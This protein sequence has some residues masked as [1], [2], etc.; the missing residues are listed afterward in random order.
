MQ[1]AKRLRRLV[2][3][4]RFLMLAIICFTIFWCFNLLS[5]AV[6]RIFTDAIYDSRF[7]E[8]EA[9]VT[10]LMR[11]VF[12]G[13]WLG[14][15]ALGLLASFY[16]VRMLNQIRVGQYFSLRTA[17]NMKQFGAALS[18]TMIMDT[19]LAAYA[20][21]VLTWGN[22]PFNPGVQGSIGYVA[23]SYYY[24]PGDIT[25]FFCGVGFFIVGWLLE[26]GGRIEEEFKAIV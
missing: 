18:I 4:S 17:R 16:A 12:G 23:P 1:D 22:A 25:A 13:L 26:E 7:V 20:H 6:P 14:T 15:I 3:V 11:A 2:N 5:W 21:S 10:L 9:N 19:I 24:D 8:T